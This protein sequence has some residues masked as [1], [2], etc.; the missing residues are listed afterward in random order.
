MKKIIVL[1]ISLVLAF[2]L[3]AQP[4]SNGN[5]PAST[6]Y[7]VT[8]IQSPNIASLG[9]YGDFPVSYFTG[10]PSIEIP[11]YEIPLE[12]KKIPIT[13]SYHSS[14]VRPDQHPGWI[15]LGWNL[16]AG[17]AI[18]RSVQDLP[19]EYRLLLQS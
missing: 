19:G 7:Q 6:R 5:I 15:G 16:N 17:G 18:Y 14:S 1:A 9:L 10:T 3:Y 8:N 2:N 13:L 11:L 12:D 4:K